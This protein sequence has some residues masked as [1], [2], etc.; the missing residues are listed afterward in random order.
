LLQEKYEISSASYHGGDL[1]GVCCHRLLADGIKIFSDTK[2]FLIQYEHQNIDRCPDTTITVVCE[3]H[4]Y[5]CGVLDN[6]SSTLRKKYGEIKEEDLYVAESALKIL[7]YLWTITN[8]GKTPNC[9][10]ALEHALKQARVIGGFGDILEDDVEMVHQIAGRFKS[11]ASKIKG[12]EKQA[13]L[14]AKMEAIMHS[15]DVQKNIKES[16]QKAKCALVINKK[17]E[18]MKRLK[19]E[20]DKAWV[21]PNNEIQKQPYSKETSTYDE[22]KDNILNNSFS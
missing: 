11:R 17:E 1:N 13:L 14:P 10:S 12:H 20:R 9:H 22:L 6:L 5:L 7:N 2:E 8:L 3:L 19:S 16:Q 4:G 21:M 15:N 18:R